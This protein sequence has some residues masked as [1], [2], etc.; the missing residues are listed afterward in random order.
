MK[1]EN[2][3]PQKNIALNLMLSA[4]IEDYIKYIKSMS[5]LKA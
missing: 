1:K 3:N 5:L 2:K 4:S